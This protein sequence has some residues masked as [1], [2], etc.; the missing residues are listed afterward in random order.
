MLQHFLLKGWNI[1]NKAKDFRKKF[2]LYLGSYSQEFQL[3]L[4]YALLVLNRS[5][6][7]QAYFTI[8]TR[9]NNFYANNLNI[10]INT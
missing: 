7:K 6:L 2:K 8:I 4:T 9:A 10:I 3:Y 5:V 1:F